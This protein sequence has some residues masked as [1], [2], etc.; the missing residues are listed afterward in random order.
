V[1]RRTARASLHHRAGRLHRATQRR[2]VGDHVLA[3]GWTSYNH[4]LR[5]QTFDVTDLLTTGATP[6]AR[7]LGDGWYRG[8]WAFT[9]GG[10]TS[11]ATGWHCWR[12]LR[13][14]T[15]TA[16]ANASSPTSTGAPP[17][18]R[19]WPATSTTARATTR[20][21]NAPAGRRPATP[22]P[23]GRACG[24]SSAT[25]RRW[26]HLPARRCAASR[27]WRRQRSLPRRRAAPS[28]TSA[29]IW[30]GGCG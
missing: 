4:R 30:S 2:D 23:T 27:K 29:R 26:S 5:Y 21:W 28:S 14:N 18:A 11:T 12:S 10:A 7:S 24:W 20:A 25:W 22:M 8:R 15:P 16:A 9:A 3:P 19:S 17:P 6:S 1:R 13:S